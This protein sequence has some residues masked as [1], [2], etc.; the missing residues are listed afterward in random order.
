MKAPVRK[1]AAPRSRLLHHGNERRLA[2]QHPRRRILSLAAGA[3]ALPAVSRQVWAQA[4]PSR[5]I[6]MVV[7]FAAGGG[8]DVIGRIIAERM[9]ALLNQPV[10]IENVTGAAGTLGVGRVRRATADGY[11]LVLGNWGTHVLNGAVYVLPYHVLND[12]EPV[13]PIVTQPYLIAAKKAAPARDLKELIAWLKANPDRASAGTSGVGSTQHVSSVFF[14]NATGTHFQFVP[15]RGG[16]QAMQDLLAGQI[17]LMIISAGESVQQVRA[18]E[19]KA[20]AVTAKSRLAEAPDIPTVDE[21]GL[22]GFYISGWTGLW[23]PAGT[24]KNVVG[25]LNAAVVDALADANVRM[26]LA[27]L[28]LETFRHDQQ[29]AGALGVLQKAE[30]EKWWPIIKGA[31]IKV[32]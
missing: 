17:D 9:R 2:T 26:Q 19:I 15:Y 5:P 10:I 27:N 11:T 1:S 7:P 29:T 28:G 12:F 8:T 20:Y 13:A 23:A 25:K 14:Q 6:T 18:G 31:N 3:A 32:E 24:P 21:A 16:G 30:I 22:P 4:Y